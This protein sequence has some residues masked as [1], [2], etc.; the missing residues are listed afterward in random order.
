MGARS[1]GLVSPHATVVT[2]ERCL[3]VA[4]CAL[5]HLITSPPARRSVEGR[6]GVPQR[7]SGDVAAGAQGAAH[8]GADT[9]RRPLHGCATQV[10][11]GETGRPTHCT[12]AFS[13][14]L[15][16]VGSPNAILR[17]L[18]VQ[19]QFPQRT[20]STALGLLHP[21]PSAVPSSHPSPT[22]QAL[23]A[24]RAI[25][26]RTVSRCRRCRRRPWVLSTPDGV[27]HPLCRSI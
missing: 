16:L 25:T 1:S 5:L 7:V 3:G 8:R 6:R 14:F 4:T 22:P 23:P 26:R 12:H 10:T 9:A 17:R 21:R 24:A 11:R 27:R 15:R 18:K 20:M 2:M 13:E 19:R